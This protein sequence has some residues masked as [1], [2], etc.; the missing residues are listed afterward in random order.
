MRRRVFK[1]LLID[2][3]SYSGSNWVKYNDSKKENIPQ[4]GPFLT[5]KK[6]SLV[7]YQKIGEED[8]V[9]PPIQATS[10]PHDGISE[11]N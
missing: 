2:S 4:I 5:S 10:L 11:K 1:L 6:T 3:I 9:E 8:I 7:F